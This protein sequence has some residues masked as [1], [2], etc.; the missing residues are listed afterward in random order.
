MS[1]LGLSISGDFSWLAYGTYSRSA[2]GRYTLNKVMIY[3]CS[4]HLHRL[5]CLTTSEETAILF[6]LHFVQRILPTNSIVFR[7]ITF[8]LIITHCVIF[9]ADMMILFNRNNTSETAHVLQSENRASLSP[10]LY[11]KLQNTDVLHNLSPPST[12]LVFRCVLS[13]ALRHSSPSSFADEHLNAPQRWLTAR[14]CDCV[15]NVARTT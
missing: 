14:C 12:E 6:C 10:T 1:S 2:Q 8:W 4:H 7:K 5:C 3:I 9:S 13:I 11:V 15:Q